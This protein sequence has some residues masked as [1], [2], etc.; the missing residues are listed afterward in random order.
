MNDVAPF[1]G[2]WFRNKEVLCSR[3]RSGFA[4]V[5]FFLRRL[6]QVIWEPLRDLREEDPNSRLGAG[7]SATLSVLQLNF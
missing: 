6:A 7:G 5:L 2:E 1:V 3:A 4:V